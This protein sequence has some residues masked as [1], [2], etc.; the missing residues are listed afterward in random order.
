LTKYECGTE[1]TPQEGEA[2]RFFYIGIRDWLDA[3][4]KIIGWIGPFRYATGEKGTWKA[5]VI[6]T[7]EGPEPPPNGDL[8][9][10]VIALEQGLVALRDDIVGALRAA[11]D[12]L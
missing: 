11:A 6:W 8:E 5:Q 10:R 4:K 7:K 3:G 2:Q 1:Y 9:K 12:R